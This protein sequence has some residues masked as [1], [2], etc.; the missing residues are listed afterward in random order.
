MSY[1]G[2]GSGAGLLAVE[3][4]TVNVGMVSMEEDSVATGIIS[5]HPSLVQ[6]IIAYDGV[7]LFIANATLAAHGITVNPGKS[8]DMNQTIADAIYQTN[9]PTSGISAASLGVASTIDIPRANQTDIITFGPASSAGTAILTLAPGATV[10]VNI[11]IGGLSA[12]AVASAFQ[13][14]PPSGWESNPDLGFDRDLYRPIWEFRC[15]KHQRFRDR[16]CSQ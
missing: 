7:S 3:K 1:G 16:V 6:N 5:N 11:P 2:S 14:T 12:D 9:L 15:S 8:L 10:T 4:R 13:S